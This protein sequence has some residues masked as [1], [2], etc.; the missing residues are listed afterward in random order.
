[1]REKN[2]NDYWHVDG[3]REWSDTWTGF[4]RFSLLNE[5]PPGGSTWSG[6]DWQENK[7]LPGQPL[8]G[9]RFGK[10]WPMHSNVKSSKSGLSRNLSSIQCQKIAWCFS[11]EMKP[12]TSSHKNSSSKRFATRSIVQRRLIYNWNPDGEKK[13]PLRNKLQESDISLT[14]K[15]HLITL[16]T[17]FSRIASTWPTTQAVQSSSTRTPSTPTSMS[18]PSTFMT[19]DEGYPIK[20]WKEN[21]DGPCKVFSHVPHFV[22]HQWA[23]RN[24]LQ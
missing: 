22:D 3:D 1:M 9:Q 19:Q 20:S 21:R 4:T 12:A 10:I 13:M 14:C 6:R 17:S 5:E 8:C 15:R 11:S 23:D 16:T 18:S 24:A 7:R 2:I